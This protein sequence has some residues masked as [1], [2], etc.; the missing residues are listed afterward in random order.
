MSYPKKKSKTLAWRQKKCFRA[1]SVPRTW[2]SERTLRACS[3]TSPRPLQQGW[4]EPRLFSKKPCYKKP[5][6]GLLRR[7]FSE[8]RRQPACFSFFYGLFFIS[9]KIS[10][11]NSDKSDELLRSSSDLRQNELV[12]FSSFK[13]NQ[14]IKNVHDV[15]IWF[16]QKFAN[17]IE[18]SNSSDAE[19]CIFQLST[20]Q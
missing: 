3:C 19:V 6:A 18:F 11:Y 15:T 12:F 9:L 10:C 2:P 14:R 7:T 16:T 8:E 20:G 4:A 13:E 5:V 17:V 1:A